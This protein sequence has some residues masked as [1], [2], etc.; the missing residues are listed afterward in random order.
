VPAL[1]TGPTAPGQASQADI[2]AVKQRLGEVPRSAPKAG[3][4]ANPIQTEPAH[5]ELEPPPAPVDLRVAPSAPGAVERPSLSGTRP[6]LKELQEARAV[7]AQTVDELSGG[8]YVAGEFITR[9]PREIPLAQ[10]IARGPGHV[11]AL[12]SDPRIEV[13]LVD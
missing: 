12:A 5:P 10:V 6:T 13:E 9:T 3:E 2:D 4:G 8:L 7:R 11:A 1:A